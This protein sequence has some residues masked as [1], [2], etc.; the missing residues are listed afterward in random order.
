MPKILNEQDLDLI[1]CSN[2][3]DLNRNKINDRTV[4]AIFNRSRHNNKSLFISH[5]DDYEL[6]KRTIRSNGNI[7]HIFKPNI[8]RGAQNLDQEK[9]VWI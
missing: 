2:L 8:F 1:F 3:E 5:R 9:K 7:Y 4:Q 6:P